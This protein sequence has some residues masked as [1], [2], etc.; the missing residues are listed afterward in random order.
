MKRIIINDAGAVHPLMPEINYSKRTRLSRAVT[1]NVLWAY[2]RT[3]VLNVPPIVIR[4]FNNMF[5]VLDGLN[6]CVTATLRRIPLRGCQVETVND[7]Y[8]HLPDECLRSLAE[9]I[10]ELSP[11]FSLYSDEAIYIE[12]TP[13][14]RAKERLRIAF[15]YTATYVSICERSGVRT[16]YDLVEKYNKR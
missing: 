6:R 3:D 10:D 7:I 14:D 8:H 11:I 9:G 5:V 1:R 16:V 13:I 4:E 15:E 12:G 2:E